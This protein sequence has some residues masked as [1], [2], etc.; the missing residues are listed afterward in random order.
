M[1]C[2]GAG[3]RDAFELELN[4]AEQRREAVE[5]EV[6]AYLDNRSGHRALTPEQTRE[7]LA[8]RLGMPPLECTGPARV[9]PLGADALGTYSRL[10]VPL[11]DGLTCDGILLLPAGA[12][13]PVPLVVAQHGGRQSPEMAIFHGGANCHGMARTPLARGYAVWAPRLYMP[14]GEDVPRRAALDRRAR[15]TGTTLLGIEQAKLMRG[16]DAI[17]ALPEVD[18]H[19]V[20]MVGLSIGGQYTLVAAALDVRLRVAV[21]SCPVLHDGWIDELVPA[22]ELLSLICPRPVQI[23]HGGA[24]EVVPPDVARA[25]ARPAALSYDRRGAGDSFEY[26]EVAGCGHEFVEEPAWQFLH[27]HLPNSRAATTTGYVV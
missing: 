22:M 24:D 7:A 17:L 15:A 6:N 16:L 5:A 4:I 14:P 23:Q 2:A 8:R 9:T 25:V 12:S 10:T 13:F 20:G 27:R 26:V 21:A 11:S 19:A 18:E 3:V 1:S